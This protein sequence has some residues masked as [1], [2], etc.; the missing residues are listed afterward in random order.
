VGRRIETPQAKRSAK[1]VYDWDSQSEEWESEATEH[2]KYVWSGWLM[3]MELDGLADCGVPGDPDDCIVRKYTRGLDLAGQMGGTGVS[4]VSL[5]S[6][7]GIGG[8]LA[9]WDADAS[10]G[11]AGGDG[12]Y[13]VLYDANGNVGQLV[14]WG[15]GV[16]D[17]DTPPA[18]LGTAWHANRL[19]ARYEY[20]PYGGVVFQDGPYADAN[21]WRFSTKQWD[22]ETGLGYW[23]YRYYSPSLG[24]WISRDPAEEQGAIV[25]RL[26]ST[27]GDS[28]PILNGD[29]PHAYCFAGNGPLMH[30]DPHGL[31]I[32]D[33]GGGRYAYAVTESSDTVA[34]LASIIGLEAGEYRKWLTAAAT[35]WA[36]LVTGA[37]PA[38]PTQQLAGGCIYLIPNTI[39]AWW[40]GE[41]AD[42]GKFWVM[43][44]Q[45]VKTFKKR[46]F[47][48]FETG[49]NTAAALEG[50]IRH[51]QD[52][53]QLHGWFSWGHGNRGFFSATGGPKKNKK[54]W[55]LYNSYYRNW[56]PYYKMGIGIIWACHSDTA[57]PEF[58]SNA[59]FAGFPGKKGPWSP[60]H[61]WGPTVEQLIPPGKQGTRQ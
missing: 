29:S 36:G 23:G 11:P 41:L 9:V 38:S 28:V 6:A 22:D 57:K 53:R 59:I 26:A 54:P 2:R 25:L 4:P 31:W 20:D 60:F 50:D 55:T 42:L 21:T 10:T 46:G 18:P 12:N 17:S 3:L 56:H 27:T 30:V 34:K 47:S 14:A 51:F 52:K 5:E 48:V 39:I 43:W 19:A 32:I 49:P 44:G 35:G 1:R 45:D 16:L 40:A 33:R 15:E 13:I 7:G 58:S 24:R 61:R 37:I 8:L